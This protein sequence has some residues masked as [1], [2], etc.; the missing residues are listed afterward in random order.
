M[1]SLGLAA[2]YVSSSLETT[3]SPETPR[4][5]GGNPSHTG[6]S[7]IIPGAI[8]IDL[9]PTGN[10]VSHEKSIPPAWD[11]DYGDVSLSPVKGVAMGSR[12][13]TQS[14]MVDEVSQL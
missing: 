5:V 9:D 10:P 14:V 12:L 7:L 4:Q 2:P 13:N 11:C 3:L 8:R 1:R 6:I